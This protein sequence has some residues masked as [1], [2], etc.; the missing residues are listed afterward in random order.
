VVR[1]LRRH[2]DYRPGRRVWA[3]LERYELRRDWATHEIRQVLPEE[4][5]VVHAFGDSNTGIRDPEFFAAE[6]PYAIC[7]RH[8]KVRLA[9]NFASDD[10]EACPRLCRASGGWPHVP[11]QP[12]DPALGLPGSRETGDSR[13]TTGRG[14]RP[15]RRPRTASPFESRRHLGL[16]PGGLHAEQLHAV[17]IRKIALA[18]SRVKLTSPV[19][20]RHS[21]ASRPDS[22]MSGWL[23][24]RGG[25]LHG[26]RLDVAALVAVGLGR[27]RECR[28]DVGLDGSDVGATAASIETLADSSR[29][30][31]AMVQRL[32]IDSKRLSRVSE[33][34]TL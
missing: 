10:D 21:R 9:V 13:P 26:R 34:T 12:R 14:L 27:H 16:R 29:A 32:L 25:R 17:A 23:K 15:G 24:D 4:L 7:G 3:A 20:M 18:R 5:G 6:G 2:R 8:V 19:P 1:Q 11:T 33:S 28:H 31:G 30:L 22:G